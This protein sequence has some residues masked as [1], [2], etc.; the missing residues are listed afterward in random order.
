MPLSGAAPPAGFCRKTV[1][2]PA[3]QAGLSGRS[4]GVPVSPYTS[5]SSWCPFPV[6]DRTPSLCRRFSSPAAVRTAR[7]VWGQSS[8]ISAPPAYW[9]QRRMRS[10]T[11]SATLRSTQHFP[12]STVPAGAETALAPLPAQRQFRRPAKSL[13]RKNLLAHRRR[14]NLAVFHGV[15]T[16]GKR[17][18]F[19]R[20]SRAGSQQVFVFFYVLILGG[21]Q[22]TFC[23]GRWLNTTPRPGGCP[24]QPPR[25]GKQRNPAR[26]TAPAGRCG[27]YSLG[28]GRTIA[29]R[30]R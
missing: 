4:Q 23:W 21:F 25:S 11:M 15:D 27:S 3:P 13:L 19:K 22:H 30:S 6:S 10:N 9:H 16:A 12:L 1:C 20:F 26:P 2:P 8:V 24:C 17:L 18:R 14:Q 28:C 5:S 29:P 7:S